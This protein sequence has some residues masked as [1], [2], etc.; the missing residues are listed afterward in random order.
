LDFWCPWE[1]GGG[2]TPK[3]ST[4]QK[5]KKPPRGTQG[6]TGRIIGRKKAPTRQGRDD[7]GLKGKLYERGV[8]WDGAIAKSCKQYRGRGIVVEKKD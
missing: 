6:R 4:D 2:Q 3:S 8:N 7:R 1:A 5:K